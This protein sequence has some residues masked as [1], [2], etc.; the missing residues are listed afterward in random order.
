MQIKTWWRHHFWPCL[1]DWFELIPPANQILFGSIIIICL[2]SSGVRISC[3]WIKKI[4]TST[5][6]SLLNTKGGLISESFSLWLKS[7]K[8]GCQKTTLS[9]FSLNRWIVLRVVIWH[10]FLEIWAWKI[11]GGKIRILPWPLNWGWNLIVF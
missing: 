4:K 3:I 7:P 11:I 1:H 9:I 5:I 8:T 10:P 6:L 2:M